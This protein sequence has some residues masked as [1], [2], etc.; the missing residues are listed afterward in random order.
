[1]TCIRVRIDK[2]VGYGSQ[3]KGLDNDKVPD[4]IKKMASPIKCTL[5]GLTYM[6]QG[7]LLYCL[8]KHITLPYSL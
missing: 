6:T 3:L 4:Q 1:M 8:D 5:Y 7:Q 2:L